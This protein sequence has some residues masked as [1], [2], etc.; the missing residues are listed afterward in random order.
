M[1]NGRPVSAGQAQ[2]VERRA[3]GEV[4][5]QVLV[6]AREDPPRRGGEHPQRLGPFLAPPAPPAGEIARAGQRAV[7]DEPE[8]VAHA[9]LAPVAGEQM[10]VDVAGR[11][12]VR[13]RG[14]LERLDAD[15]VAQPAQRR[16]LVDDERLR[17]L[18]PLVKDEQ[19][20][21]GR[22]TVAAGDGRELA[23]SAN[24][25][26]HQALALACMFDVRRSSHPL[27]SARGRSRR[28][29][30]AVHR[31]R[32]VGPRLLPSG[33]GRFRG[34]VG[35]R[36]RLCALSQGR[37]RGRRHDVRQPGGAADQR[38]AD[39]RGR[40]TRHVVAPG[41]CAA[42]PRLLAERADKTLPDADLAR[43]EAHLAE[44]WACR[45][46]VARFKA[47]ER[48]Y[49]DPPEPK[50]DPAVAEQ[51]LA[52]LVAAVPPPPEPEPE[53]PVLQAANGAA[54]QRPRPIPTPPR[55]SSPSAS[56]GRAGAGAG[57]VRPRGRRRRR[58]QQ[59]AGAATQARAARHAVAAGRPVAARQA[60]RS[61][62][63][64]RT[65]ARAGARG[66]GRRRRG[67]HRLRGRARERGRRARGARTGSDRRAGTRAGR[68]D[69]AR[70]DPL[71]G[72]RIRAPAPRPARVRA[73]GACRSCCRSSSSSSP[74]SWRCS[75]PASSAAA[76][77][78]PARAS[79][80]RPPRPPAPS[81]GGSRRRARG[82]GRH[83]RRGRARQGARPRPPA[84]RDA[85]RRQ[86]RHRG[87]EDR[88][89]RRRPR[90]PRPPPATPATN[91]APPPPPPPPP[92]PAATKRPSG[93]KQIDAGSGATGA[94]QIPP[95]ADTSDVPD[96]A[97][98]TD[99]ATSP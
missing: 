8:Q 24:R 84:R 61:A 98:P 90:L 83:R 93:Q 15:V 21:H 6:A 43:L 26:R 54:P 23:R 39:V 51:I 69:H 59:R 25:H 85:A 22:R 55:P 75:S 42:V 7:G 74:C 10:H 63:G 44:C 17:Q 13:V 96:L 34:R 78:S 35:G 2:G 66:A 9:A 65:R 5:V 71:R 30:R 58:D 64:A 79:R 37:R 20:P 68:R 88:R 47:A 72:L 27:R 87:E 94:E 19:Q 29:G 70:P 16:Q 92:P 62:A 67:R 32:A 41:H 4:G 36:R 12:G 95:P 76:S 73:P 99:S 46:P 91:A 28:A 3:G 18:R 86:E 38:D 31:A 77:P 82:Q 80:C 1:L 33:G 89:R 50:L 81:T 48:A 57:R 53:P 45:A 40:S 56:R 52:A 97:P 11:L 49:L 14:R 60:P